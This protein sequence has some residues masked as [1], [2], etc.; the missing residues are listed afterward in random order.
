MVVAQ[1]PASVLASAGDGVGLALG[2]AA[3]VR[4]TRAPGAE[5][6]LSSQVNPLPRRESWIG[7]ELLTR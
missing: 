4:K 6:A 1:W 7:L 5:P 2:V 3:G